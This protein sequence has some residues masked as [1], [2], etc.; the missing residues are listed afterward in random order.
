MVK[1]MT[2]HP[3]C[4]QNSAQNFLSHIIPIPGKFDVSHVCLGGMDEQDFINGLQELT[5]V[6]KA[7][8]AD[9]IHQPA[10]YG[11]PTVEDIEYDSYNA[12]AAE[13]R[14]SSQR[15]VL[16]LYALSQGGGMKNS[17]LHIDSKLLSELCKKLKITNSKKILTRFC[18]HGFVFESDMFSYPGNNNVIP[19]LCGYMNAAELKQNAFFSLNYF[20]AADK[21]PPQQDIFANYLQGSEH[22]FFIQLSKFLGESYIIGNAPDYNPLSFALEYWVDDKNKKRLV[23]CYSHNGELLVRLKLH[24]SDCYDH[25]TATLP[26]HIKQ[27][28]RKPESCRHCITNCN[29]KLVR[30]FDGASYVDCGYGNFFDIQSYDLADLQYYKQLLLLE[31]KA[32]KSGA[33]RK[34]KKVTL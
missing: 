21:L 15:L 19:A 16:L 22:E 33:R 20:I 14:K 23:R 34:G 6:V 31:V 30:S 18:N 12:K 5:A 10:E 11:L 28:L 26:G 25:F 32:E 17:T 29:A 8:Y 2:K 7:I 1:H 9:A 4:C 13:S 27:M 3:Y 24:S